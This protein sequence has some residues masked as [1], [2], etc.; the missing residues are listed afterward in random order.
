MIFKEGVKSHKKKPE[1]FYYREQ[2]CRSLKII[3]LREQR[4]SLK[5][6]LLIKVRVESLRFDTGTS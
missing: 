1:E 2:E 3:D 6:L 5:W 4:R